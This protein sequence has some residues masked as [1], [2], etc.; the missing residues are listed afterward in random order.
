MKVSQ[1]LARVICEIVDPD[2]GGQASLRTGISRGY[3]SD[4]FKGKVPRPE[5]LERIIEGYRDRITPDQIER[6]YETAGYDLPAKYVQP[7]EMKQSED[8]DPVNRVKYALYGQI[9]DQEQLRELHRVL[10]MHLEP[11]EKKKKE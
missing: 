9:I 3:W 11:A 10:Q 5:A 2:T 4:M 7:G 6:L 8:P 1:D